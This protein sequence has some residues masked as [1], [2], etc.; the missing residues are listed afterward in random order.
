MTSKPEDHRVTHLPVIVGYGGISPAGRSSFAHAYRRLIFDALNATKKQ[1]TLA[2]LGQLMQV[3]VDAPGA[4][5]QILAG[6]LIRQLDPALLD[7]MAVPSNHAMQ[8]LGSAQVPTVFEV[9]TRHL[10]KAIPPQWQLEPL[11][12]GNTRVTINGLIGGR[13][14]H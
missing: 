13:L 3:A 14:S 10:P 6:T 1:A 4:E 11:V 8:A 7:P 9:T 5:E 12:N 2:S